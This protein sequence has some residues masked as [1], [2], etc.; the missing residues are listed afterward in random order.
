MKPPLPPPWHNS[1]EQRNSRTVE[2]LTEAGPPRQAGVGAAHLPLTQRPRVTGLAHAEPGRPARIL[3]IMQCSAVC[4][5]LQNL[6][7]DAP[8]VAGGLAAHGAVAL[9][10]V[11]PRHRRSE[12]LNLGIACNQP[13]QICTIVECETE[14]VLKFLLCCSGL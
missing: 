4:S 13:S 11:L 14:P 12:Q 7:A 2:Y 5:A 8:V 10:H 3:Q 6:V 9:L 1:R